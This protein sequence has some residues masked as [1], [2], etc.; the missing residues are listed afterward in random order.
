M[1]TTTATI[2]KSEKIKDVLNRFRSISP[3][4]FGASVITMEGFMV[5]SVTLSEID[6][7]LV[8]GLTAAMLGVGERIASE[9]MNSRM[10]QIYVKS[11]NG[12]I[13]CNSINEETVLV[14][15]VNSDAKL[16]LIFLEI[17]RI[18]PDLASLI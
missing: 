12:Y 13:I 14:S 8:G 17:R 11:D 6:E 4:I 5:A 16:G 18:L 2:S 10:S 7:G 9:M 3:D 15:L 1:N